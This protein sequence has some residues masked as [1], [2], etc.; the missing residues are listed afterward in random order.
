MFLCSLI[1]W[2]HCC[3][4]TR[5]VWCAVDGLDSTGRGCG[6]RH[7]HG[8]GH[9]WSRLTELIDREGVP[10]STL[11]GQRQ[12]SV[13]D[14]LSLLSVACGGGKYVGKCRKSGKMS[15]NWMKQKETATHVATDDFV[16]LSRGARSPFWGSHLIK[17]RS[18]FLISNQVISSLF[19]RSFLWIHFYL[20]IAIVCVG[21]CVWVCDGVWKLHA[22]FEVAC[23]L[24]QVWNGDSC[25]RATNNTVQHSG[26]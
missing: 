11:L 25:W 7:G 1:E 2:F 3:Y 9:G 13:M 6:H 4:C 10:A 8:H 22:H 17:P 24:C 12:S 14:T 5:T 19:T 15:I 18:V 21:V 20:L 23:A 26:G 16:W